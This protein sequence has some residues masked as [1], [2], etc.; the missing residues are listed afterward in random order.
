MWTFT[1]NPINPFVLLKNRSGEK[2]TA[3]TVNAMPLTNVLLVN[4]IE[5][6]HTETTSILCSLSLSVNEPPNH[7][8]CCNYVL[9]QRVFAWMIVNPGGCINKVYVRYLHALNYTPDVFRFLTINTFDRGI[10]RSRSVCAIMVVT[11]VLSHHEAHPWGV[12]CSIGPRVWW[13]SRVRD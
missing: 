1:L 3:K 6:S 4:W 12:K 11:I 7:P 8:M 2:R 9:L 13:R 10:R 5:Y